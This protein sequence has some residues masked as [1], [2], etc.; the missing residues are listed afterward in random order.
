MNPSTAQLKDIEA[1][2]KDVD[3]LIATTAVKLQ[4]TEDTNDWVEAWWWK[5]AQYENEFG[6]KQQL[7]DSFWK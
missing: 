4:E 6:Q 5:W 3:W 1:I 7:I 2:I